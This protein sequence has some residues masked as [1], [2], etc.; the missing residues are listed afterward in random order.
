MEK[1]EQEHFECIKEVCKDT[2]W[3]EMRLKRIPFYSFCSGKRGRTTA[4]W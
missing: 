1:L 3:F 4:F 2:G